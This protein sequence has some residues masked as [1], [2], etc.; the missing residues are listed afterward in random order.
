MYGL[1]VNQKGCP[2][3]IMHKIRQV[4]VVNDSTAFM[5]LPGSISMY[6]HR[7]IQNVYNTVFNIHLIINNYFVCVFILVFID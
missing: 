7:N 6:L 2:F 5:F 4:L 3:F 1:I